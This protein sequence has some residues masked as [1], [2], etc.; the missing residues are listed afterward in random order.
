MLAASLSSTPKS[1]LEETFRNVDLTEDTPEIAST[2][3][4][5]EEPPEEEN[6]KKGLK[7]LKNRLKHFF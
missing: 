7:G 3:G 5:A 1:R 6:P 2:S 4:K